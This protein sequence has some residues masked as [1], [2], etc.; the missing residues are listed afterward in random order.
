MEFREFKLLIKSCFNFKKALPL[1]YL[2]VG[3]ILG[4]ICILNYDLKSSHPKLYD[5]LWSGSE[6]LLISALLSFLMTTAKYIGVFKEAVNEIIYD[7]RF[8]S[9]RKDIEKVWEKVSVSLF[10]AKFPDISHDFLETIKKYYIPINEDHFYDNYRA[11][12]DI[13]W[14]DKENGWIK[15]K[16]DVDYILN[17]DSIK[18][19]NFSFKS[20][21][22]IS[23]EETPGSICSS[24]TVVLRYLVDGKE[25]KLDEN[26]DVVVQD[27]EKIET[28]HV[29]LKGKQKYNIRQEIE[30]TMCLDYDNFC[31]FN[32]KW[33]VNNMDIQVYFPTDMHVNFVPK[34][35]AN[36]FSLVNKRENSLRYEYKGL[37]LRSQGYLFILTKK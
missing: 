9:N 30:K 26:P 6:I 18:E 15:I 3:L 25:I 28:F 27:G 31:A 14:L 34:G 1:L 11:I 22:K 17:T 36:K 2:C 19:N 7:F 32:C 35:T 33:L 4:T 24:R 8:L 13:Q 10:N 12:I 23:D 16:Y 29:K 21:T 20:W 5:I 37:I